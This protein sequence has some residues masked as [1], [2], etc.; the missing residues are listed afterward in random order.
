M[1]ALYDK[2]HRM[3]QLGALVWL[4]WRLF[5]N[6][7]R[8]GKAVTTRLASA[9]AMLAALG[10]SLLVGFGLGSAAYFFAS[11]HAQENAELSKFAGGALAFFFLVFSFVYL[12]WAV[13]PL[14]LEGGSRFEPR[15]MM[16]YPISLGKLFAV[17]LLSELTNLSSVFAVPV[18]AGVALGAGLALRGVGRALVLAAL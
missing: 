1:R 16:L 18:V 15:R 8:T 3:S 6:S 7:L 9:L 10:F 17:D 13:V 4:K 14:G 5:R 2:V 12:M 11:P